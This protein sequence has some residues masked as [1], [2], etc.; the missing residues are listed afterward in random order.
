M[1]SVYATLYSGKCGK[2]TNTEI[3]VSENGITAYQ[4]KSLFTLCIQVSILINFLDD[5]LR[6]S[7]SAPGDVG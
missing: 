3:R 7:E 6:N 4:S 1:I 5:W 2:E